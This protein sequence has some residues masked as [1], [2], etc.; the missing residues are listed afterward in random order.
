MM[1]VNLPYIG[2]SNQSARDQSQ[3]R[4]G[5]ASPL[6]A[7]GHPDPRPAIGWEAEVEK[8]IPYAKGKEIRCDVLIQRPEGELYIEI[9]QELTRNNIERAREK[10]RNWKAFSISQEFVPVYGVSSSTAECQDW[11]IHLPSG[12]MRWEM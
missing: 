8:V 7:A 11:P 10:F 6:C 1:R 5:S 3:R 2:F 9:E 12:S 4:E